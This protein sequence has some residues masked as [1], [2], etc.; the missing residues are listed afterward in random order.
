MDA[1]TKLFVNYMKR[2]HAVEVNV[3]DIFWEGVTLYHDEIDENL[4]PVKEL[5][6]LPDPLLFLTVVYDDRFDQNYIFCIAMENEKWLH[7]V[8]VRN[9]E[10][11]D[12]N[13]PIV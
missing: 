13:V 11:Y 2:E 1:A 3:D 4:F 12:E 10:L 6:G 5:V 7:A 9:G 8:C